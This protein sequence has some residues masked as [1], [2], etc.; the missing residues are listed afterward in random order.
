MKVFDTIH[1]CFLKVND[2]G[3]RNVYFP[4]GWRL[5]KLFGYHE[6]DP[7]VAFLL[8]RQFDFPK[9]RLTV[10]RRYDH[11]NRMSDRCLRLHYNS[12][13]Y[14]SLVCLSQQITNKT[15][16]NLKIPKNPNTINCTAEI[17][18]R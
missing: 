2:N 3:S 7:Y 6:Y 9:N 12:N 5:L 14:D 13:R 1:F 4:G 8:S 17:L 18:G 10:R 16:E 15:H 11:I